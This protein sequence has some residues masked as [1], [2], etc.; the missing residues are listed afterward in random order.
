L[1]LR[2]IPCKLIIV[3]ELTKVQHQLLKVYGINYENRF[4]LSET[5]IVDTYRE[6]DMVSFCSLLEG[7]GLPILEGQATG[8]VVITSNLSSMPDVAG[9]GALLVDP[10]DVGAIRKGILS[11]IQDEAFRNSL[12]DMGLENVK[13]F[14]AQRVADAYVE[15]Y[16]VIAEK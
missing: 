11:V 13:R 9:K 14:S 3:G 1:A 12:V 6:C 5:Q 15:L 10:Y 7:F 2:N 4:N 16:R 8:R